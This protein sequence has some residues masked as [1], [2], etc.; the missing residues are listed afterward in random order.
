MSDYYGIDWGTYW[1]DFNYDLPGPG[2]W[3]H[4]AFEAVH[5]ADFD[6]NQALARKLQ[7][8]A[9]D[10]WRRYAFNSYRAAVMYQDDVGFAAKIIDL[11]TMATIKDITDETSPA[12]KAYGTFSYVN[13]AMDEEYIFISSVVS[14]VNVIKQFNI[15]SGALVRHIPEPAGYKF[16]CDKYED[17]LTKNSLLCC[18]D[19][20]LYV[21][22]STTEGTTPTRVIAFDVA[23]GNKLAVFATS[24]TRILSMSA[25]NGSL[26]V[27]SSF[28]IGLFSTSTHSELWFKTADNIRAELLDK[29]Q[30]EYQDE[31]NFFTP[32]VSA[33]NASSVYICNASSL[34]RIAVRLSVANGAVH[35]LIPVRT[36]TISATDSTVVFGDDRH[37]LTEGS[38]VSI[39]KLSVYDQVSEAVTMEIVGPY[40]E[41][42]GSLALGRVVYASAGIIA[43]IDRDGLLSFS[44]PAWT[45][46]DFKKRSIITIPASM[47]TGT[48]QDIVARVVIPTVVNSLDGAFSEFANGYSVNSKAV[49]TSMDG[50]EVYPTSVVIDNHNGGAVNILVFF[51]VPE[52][53][54]AEDNKYILYH[55]NDKPV[56]TF[57]PH[58]VWTPGRNVVRHNGSLSVR[59]LGSGTLIY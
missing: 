39:G 16:Y 29:Y 36:R 59:Q 32:E 37:P 23:S 14:G 28:G 18:H 31:L 11:R 57:G 55:A 2:D 25:A 50:S 45:L 15:S 17:Y 1:D 30:D 52:L 4:P 46:T 43:F 49:V 13:I 53:S 8:F 5:T 7:G 9:D 48:P 19:G 34:Y 24:E 44:S 47:V 6:G 51:R 42:L 20:K 12:D 22:A 10:H 3:A 38:W 41:S 27:S 21:T 40:S 26:S 58:E 56:S 35:S 33:I 54:S